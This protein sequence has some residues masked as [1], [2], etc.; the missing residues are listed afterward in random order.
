MGAPIEGNAREQYSAFVDQVGALEEEIQG[1]PINRD[2]A[3]RV[4][5]VYADIVIFRNQ[6][7]NQNIQNDQNLYERTNALYRI[8]RPEIARL[9]QA[10][11]ANFQ[12]EI[13]N[14]AVNKQ[15]LNEALAE[16]P[17]GSV[18]RELFVDQ[19]NEM[20]QSIDEEL[21]N[22]ERTRM[23][24]QVQMLDPAEEIVNSIHQRNVIVTE[25]TAHIQNAAALAVEEMEEMERNLEEPNQE[26]VAQAE[27]L[28]EQENPD[29]LSPVESD[30]DQDLDSDLE[31]P[32]VG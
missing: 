10:L 32:R 4:Q 23:R 1:H 3:Q 2:L 7:Q 29:D 27:V 9:K 28:E 5:S 22:Q 30:S 6:I 17:E 20:N 24:I 19:V 13:D 16:F 8:V 18:R 25:M 26:E 15:Q 14:L 12:R 21:E 11:L 31:D